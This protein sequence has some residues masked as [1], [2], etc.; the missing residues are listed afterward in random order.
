MRI[1]A[2]QEKVLQNLSFVRTDGARVDPQFRLGDKNVSVQVRSLISYGLIE[3][4]GE[5]LVALERQAVPKIDS[6]KTDAAIK[7]MRDLLS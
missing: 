3:I 2:K 6:H 4:R 1:T 7:A 5:R